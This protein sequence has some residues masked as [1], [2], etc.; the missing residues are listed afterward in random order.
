MDYIVLFPKNCILKTPCVDG[1]R[2]SKEV[3][4]A[5]SSYK[6]GTLIQYD[7]CLYKKRQNRADP[8]FIYIPRLRKG[9]VR[10]GKVAICGSQEESIQH[11]SRVLEHRYLGSRTNGKTI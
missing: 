7:Q 1:D 3:I 6:E 10:I 9:H 4:D 2:E 5:K 11:N 8:F